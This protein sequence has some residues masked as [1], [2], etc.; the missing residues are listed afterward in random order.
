MTSPVLTYETYIRASAQRVWQALTS[1]EFTSMYF[2]GTHVESTWKPGA[3][4]KYFNEPGG[5]VAVDGEVLEADPP[6]KLVIT[7][8]V[9]YDDDARAEEPSRVSFHIEEMGEQTRLRIV[10]DEFPD[11]SVVPDS[12]REGWPWIIASL[13]SLLETGDALPAPAN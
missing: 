2:Y 7:W 11:N 5:T 6:N 3:P 8:H 10:H 4:V 13:K 9:H 1:A 12:V